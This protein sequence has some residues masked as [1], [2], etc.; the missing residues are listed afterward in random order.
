M[1][2]FV[3]GGFWRNF[4]VKYP[5]TNEM[6]AR[7]QMVSRRLQ[8]AASSY[9][10]HGG[11]GAQGNGRFGSESLV[12]QARTELYR[13]QCNCAYWHGAF[14]GAYLPHLR[15]AIF[16]HL[17]SAD[18]LLDEADG[19]GLAEGDRPWVEV[20]SGDYNLDGRPEVRLASNRLLALV[21][22]AQGGQMYEL[23]IRSI[24]HNLLATLSAPRG[25]VSS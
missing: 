14:G 21:A 22:P 18:N 9:G 15:N 17:I 25:S 12:D 11:N 6:Y 5:E 2:P 3:R 23:D 10:S 1:A 24:C 16:Q 13:G 19:R 20:T 7:M 4:K 8:E